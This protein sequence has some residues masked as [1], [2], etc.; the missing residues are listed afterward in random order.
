[1]MFTQR[2]GVCNGCILVVSRHVHTVRHKSRS[3]QLPVTAQGNKAKLWDSQ[4]LVVK[5]VA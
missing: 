5:V 2:G 3:I 1:M 4:P